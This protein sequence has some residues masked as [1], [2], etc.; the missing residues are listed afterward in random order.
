MFAASSGGYNTP[1]DTGIASTGSGNAIPID[2]N[3]DGKMELLVPYSGGTWWL[4]TISD[5]GVGSISNTGAAALSTG[6]D[7][8]ALDYDGD[9][10]QDLVWGE[11]NTTPW[12]GGEVIRWRKRSS[13]GPGFDPAVDVVGPTVANE[14]MFGNLFGDWA[15]KT[16]RRTPDFNGDGRGDL[17]YRYKTRSGPQLIQKQFF[18]VLCPGAAACLSQE[19]TVGGAPYFGDLNGD[20]LSDLIYLDQYGIYRY[21]FSTG[22]SFTGEGS[23]GLNSSYGWIVIFDWDN[24]GFDDVLGWHTS[25]QTWHV[26]RSTGE[27]L[28]AP[29]STGIVS[30]DPAATV[31]TDLNGDRLPDLAYRG[32]GNT[33]RYRAHTASFEYPD[34]LETATDGFGVAA[35]FAYRP[36]TQ[37][38]VY[39]KGTGATFPVIDSQRP[40]WVVSTL[41]ATDGT[42]NNSTFTLAHTYEAARDHLRGRGFLGFEKRNVVDSRLGYNIKTLDTYRQ[43]FPYIGAL[44]S[45]ERKRS[46]GQRLSLESNTWDHLLWGAAGSTERRF[47]F[48]RTRTVHEHELDGPGTKYRTVST[49]VAASNGIDTTSGLILDSTTTT[50]D[51]AGG[52]TKTER[53]VHSL[54]FND[55]SNWCLGRPTDTAITKSHTLPNGGA[56][57]RNFDAT[58]DGPKCRPTQ[59]RVEPNNGTWRVTVD[60]GYDAFGNVASETVTGAGMTARTTL[61]GWGTRGH[62]PQ[63]LTNP[64]N[65]VTNQTWNE[66]FGLPASVTDP[67][68][69]Q[70]TW[71][72]DEFGRPTLET[73][74]DGTKTSW[75]Y[76]L[77]PSGCD[78]RVRYYVVEEE[79]DTA[80]AVFKT[81]IRYFNRWDVVG[82]EYASLLDTEAAWTAVRDF[83]ARGRVIT[84][85]VPYRTTEAEQ[86]SRRWTYDQLDRV[87]TEGLYTSGGALERSTTYAYAGLASTATDP[88]SHQTTRLSSAWGELVSVTDAASGL[89]RYEYDAFGQLKKT[90]DAANNV[91]ASVTYNLR[92]FRTQLADLDLGT[93]NYTPNALG[94]VVSQTD[95]KGQTTAFTYD[96]LGRMLTRDGPGT[97]SDATWTWGTSAALDEIGRL[98]SLAGTNYSEAFE[99]DTA[100]RAK[101]RTIVSDATY[102]YDY[103]Y[104]GLGQLHT[105]T[106]PVTTAAARF[107]LKYLYNHGHLEAIRQFTS[108]VDGTTYWALNALNARGQAIDEVY[109][110]G[111][112]LQSTFKTLTGEIATRQSGTVGSPNNIQDLAYSW[113]TAGNL[114]ERQDLRQSKVETLTYDALDRLTGASGPGGTQTIGYNAIGNVTSRSD[115]GGGA[116]WT[117]HASKKHAV[118]SA[119]GVSYGYDAN[120][121]MTSR[122]GST[123]SW[124]SA[125]QPATINGNGYTAAFDYAP[126]G[127]RWR[128]VASY[129]EGTTTTLYVGGLLEKQITPEHTNYNHLIRTPSG[130][131]RHQRRSGGYIVT[132]YFAGDHLGST[133]VVQNAGGA[134]SVRPSFTAFGARRDDDWN[135]L[136]STAELTAIANTSRRGFTGHEMLDNVGLVHMNGRVYDPALGR[137]ISADPFIDGETNPQGWNRYAYVQNRPCS[138]TDPSGF[139]APQRGFTL[140]NWQNNEPPG[141]FRVDPITG[142]EEWVFSGDRPSFDFESMYA[143]QGMLGGGGF[144]GSSGRGGEGG[145]R[146]DGDGDARSPAHAQDQA[147]VPCPGGMSNFGTDM[148]RR[149][150]PDLNRNIQRVMVAMGVTAGVATF[151]AVMALPHVAIPVGVIAETGFGSMLSAAALEP[152]AS[153]VVLGSAAFWGAGGVGAVI[154]FHIT[155]PMPPGCD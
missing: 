75:S 70:T 13:S 34:V 146:G 19:L 103:A 93:W 28:L 147:P 47:P 145:G 74:P 123:L 85:Y 134:V 5:S 140:R 107:K 111:L 137:F 76:S 29:V 127:S 83:D 118:T 46:T 86:G 125:N 62:F 41:T 124:T 126:D 65:Q 53:V 88:L 35:T 80:N 2:H 12:E 17:V 151:A 105:L 52:W 9:G 32:S 30:S 6:I 154:G 91:V 82:W 42:G 141:E 1:I 120:G 20:G 149:N 113:D 36:I 16:P 153:A 22:T 121:N 92:G 56:L 114:T 50:T 116:A 15:Q 143:L 68:G 119:G 7:T 25:S 26:A 33:W 100:G 37:S 40:L 72:Y 61:T 129:A 135:G 96:K 39:T 81:R 97:D 63:S 14:W 109:G 138:A 57:T 45:R 84:Q 94:E 58:W 69:I 71:S 99:Y 60:L 4:L 55:T 66:L 24:D 67:N 3:S 98:K 87:V 122:A 77:C 155:R 78:A 18:V 90:T 108:D 102:A 131:V 112:W 110:N 10:R 49:A 21:R 48:V 139:G 101:K 132:H 152:V 150:N 54:P 133:D 31:V 104:N 106:Y 8:R 73:R 142:I 79:R 144:A 51:V 136:P 117:Y 23:T 11:F 59:Q 95:A 130:F 43:D 128:Q 148:S 115:V 89:M 38:S 44:A 27:A 64:L